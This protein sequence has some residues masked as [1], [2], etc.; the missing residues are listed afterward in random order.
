MSSS[1]NL[2]IHALAVHAESAD[3]VRA[4]VTVRMGNPEVGDRVWFEAT[5]RVKREL[6]IVDI[7]RSDRLSTITFSGAEPDLKH[8]VGGTYLYGLDVT[9]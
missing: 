7:K 3:N 6:E 9:R 8:F 1:E 4:R 5:D 2:L